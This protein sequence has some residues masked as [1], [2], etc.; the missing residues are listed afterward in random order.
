MNNIYISGRLYIFNLIFI[1]FVIMPNLVFAQTIFDKNREEAASID[2]IQPTPDFDSGEINY[3]DAVNRKFNFKGRV[4]AVYKDRIVIDDTAI[5]LAD[6]ISFSSIKKG[7]YVGV[8]FNEA[9]KA[10]GIFQLQNIK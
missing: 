5:P 2:M 10:M 7:N 3:S 8:Q 4:D 6:N 9:G 1:L